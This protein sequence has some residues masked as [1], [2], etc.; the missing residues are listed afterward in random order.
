LSERSHG[1]GRRRL[2]PEATDLALASFDAA[3]EAACRGAEI[4]SDRIVLNLERDGFAADL[5]LSVS[6]RKLHRQR[7]GQWRTKLEVADPQAG[8]RRHIAAFGN[9]LG[10]CDLN[11]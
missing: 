3:A 9:P 4:E 10:G 5:R 8:K 6:A 1:I 7:A 11:S 2:D